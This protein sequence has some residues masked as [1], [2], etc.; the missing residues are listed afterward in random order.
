MAVYSMTPTFKLLAGALH[1]FW[2]N[3]L[4]YYAIFT[5]VLITASSSSSRSLPGLNQSVCLLSSSNNVTECAALS[6]DRPK[7]TAPPRAVIPVMTSCNF[8]GSQSPQSP[9]PTPLRFVNA[10]SRLALFTEPRFELDFPARFLPSL[11]VMLA[12]SNLANSAMAFSDSLQISFPCESPLNQRVSLPRWLSTNGF[13]ALVESQSNVFAGLRRTL[14]LKR[15][16]MTGIHTVV[17]TCA[18]SDS[19]ATAIASTST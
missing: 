17:A 9:R 18:L 12:L 13:I 2:S 19:T 14:L 16:T 8:P 6:R 5:N 3:L 15:D 7:V 10:S 4:E 1:V 11:W